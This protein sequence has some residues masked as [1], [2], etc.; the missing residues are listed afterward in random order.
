MPLI[1]PVGFL[2]AGAAKTQSQ[3]DTYA[4]GRGTNLG[5][6]STTTNLYTQ[7]VATTTYR[8]TINSTTF[9]GA[10]YGSSWHANGA[11]ND[12]TLGYYLLHALPSSAVLT[13]LAGGGQSAII[14]AITATTSASFPSVTR[15]GYASV[16]WG[17]SYASII[18]T[19]CTYWDT[20]LGKAQT[21]NPSTQTGPVDLIF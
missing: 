12:S 6:L 18:C 17:S 20:A 8:F 16:F 4:G 2:A 5:A 9:S 1:Y 3:Y 15:N 11:T 13:Q 7:F 19:E 21:L 14:M 10:L